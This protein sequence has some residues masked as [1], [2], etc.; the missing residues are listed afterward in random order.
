[1]ETVMQ[2]VHNDHNQNR[3]KTSEVDDAKQKI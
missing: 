3:R 1:M 2:P